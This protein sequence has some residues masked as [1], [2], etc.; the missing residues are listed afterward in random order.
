[1]HSWN[2]MAHKDSVWCNVQYVCTI[3][4]CRK[5][6][7]V[8]Q[9]YTKRKFRQF[10]LDTAICTQYIGISYCTLYSWLKLDKN[11]LP[12]WCWSRATKI[13]YCYI[14]KSHSVCLYPQ[15][16][17]GD[18]FGSDL[19]VEGMKKITFKWRDGPFLKALKNG[20]WILLDEVSSD[21]CITHCITHCTLSDELSLSVS[22]WGIECLFGS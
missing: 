10:L 15:Q 6:L 18:L 11:I 2:T 17:I 4:E 12:N 22:T 9:C 21:Y 3:K 14:H 5:S 13:L 8:F 20:D 16:D 19:P 7:V 1:M